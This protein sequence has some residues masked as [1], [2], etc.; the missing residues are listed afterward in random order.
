MGDN[1][2][3]WDKDKE[4]GEALFKRATGQSPEMESSKAMAEVISGVIEDNDLIADVGCG[5]G[6]YLASLDKNV[7][8]HFSYLGIDATSYYIELAK[9]AF[10]ENKRG[11]PL[12]LKTAFAVGDIF[13]LPVN[14][15][16]AE[17]AMCSNLL[18]HL[19]SIARPI[20]ELWRIT[21]RYVII[22][23]LIGKVSFRIK[24]INPPEKYTESGE[25]VNFH[26]FNIYSEKYIESLVHGFKRVKE[27]KLFPDLEFVVAN[28]GHT[29]YKDKIAP[30][31]LTT[32]ING[33]QVNNYIILPWQI[34]IITKQ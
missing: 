1:W 29:N 32:I 4:Y 20:Q 16:S 27:Y 24:Q 10:F 31:D 28:I 2:R 14:D 11:S 23:T 26:Y 30:H 34:L 9:K 17:I 22:R 33:M 25:P 18:H 15:E 13:N 19:P 21:K 5:A 12:R 8:C 3:V 7:K 6:H